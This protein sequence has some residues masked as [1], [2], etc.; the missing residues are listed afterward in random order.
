MEVKVLYNSDSKAGLGGETILKPYGKLMNKWGLCASYDLKDY[1]KHLRTVEIKS[2]VSVDVLFHGKEHSNI[3]I[4][5]STRVRFDGHHEVLVTIDKT[6]DV[7]QPDK[8]CYDP[9]DHEGE[10][11]GEHDYRQLN[12]IILARFNCTT[13]FIPQQF[14]AGD[15]ICTNPSIGKN[16]HLMLEE[17]SASFNPNIFKENFHSLPPCVYHTFSVQQTRT[18]GTKLKAERNF[19]F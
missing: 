16:V 13:P 18:D 15:E 10:P 7:N 3:P 2:P 4:E 19:Y 5:L 6:I 11:Y 8:P 9:A 12:K 17:M 14:R 1:Q